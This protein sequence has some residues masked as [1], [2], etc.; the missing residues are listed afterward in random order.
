MNKWT[1]SRRVKAKSISGRETKESP[2]KGVRLMR[3][4]QPRG[5]APHNQPWKPTISVHFCGPQ[6]ISN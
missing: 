1:E 6:F 5:F 3:E 2:V 4:E